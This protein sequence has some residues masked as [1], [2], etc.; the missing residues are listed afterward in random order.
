MSDLKLQNEIARLKSRVRVLSKSYTELSVSSNKEVAYLKEKL[1]KTNS[2]PC[3]WCIGTSET[4][5]SL[6][7]EVEDLKKAL[8]N[9]CD[10][11]VHVGDISKYLEIEAM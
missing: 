3:N 2:I 10:L 6:E 5:D 4:I 9:D 7:Y 1:A 11:T 8:S